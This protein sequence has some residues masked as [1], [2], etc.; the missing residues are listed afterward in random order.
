M[1][2]TEAEANATKCCGPE[3]CGT[4]V[5]HASAELQAI[6]VTSF[7][8]DGMKTRNCC[9]TACMAWRFGPKRFAERKSIAQ[10]LQTAIP[11]DATIG[12]LAGAR[13]VADQLTRDGWEPDRASVLLLG[14]HTIWGK[15]TEQLGFCGLAGKPQGEE[16]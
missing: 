11:G 15:G 7:N 8:P 9:T 3:T 5:Q 13:A 10:Q 4:F 2:K 14:V 16:R 12:A 1:Y 6:S